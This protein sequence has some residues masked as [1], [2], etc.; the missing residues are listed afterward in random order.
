MTPDQIAEIADKG[1]DVSKFYTGKGKMLS[2]IQRVN[3]D[4]TG[5]MLAELDETAKTLNTS[6]QAV[7]KMFLRQSL[8]QHYIAKKARKTE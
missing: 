6:R 5:E 8:D 7:I 4:L 1:K 3:V 2:P